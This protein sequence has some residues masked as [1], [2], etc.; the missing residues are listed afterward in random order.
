MAKEA[1]V[2]VLHQ[3]KETLCK[4]LEV[5]VI[6]KRILTPIKT[7]NLSYINPQ[8]PIKT[9]I[10]LLGEIYKT[11]DKKKLNKLVNDTDE[12]IKFNNELNTLIRKA[13]LLNIPVIM[14]I[15][16]LETIKI[17]DKEIEFILATQE[18]YSDFY[19]VPS[20]KRAGKL[21]KEGLEIDEYLNFIKKFI[22]LLES[23]K[24]KP[25]MGLIPM[26]LPFIGQLVK[27]YLKHNI[28]A[29]CLDFDGRASTSLIQNISQLQRTLKNI[30]AF[31]HATN[32]NIGRPLKRAPVIPAKDVLSYGFGI[33]SLGEN[34]LPPRIPEEARRRLGGPRIEEVKNLR[35]FNKEDYGYYK[36]QDKNTL[37]KIYPP[38]TNINL[39][40]LLDKSTHRRRTAQSMFNAEQISIETNRLK[41]VIKE[42]EVAKYLKKK[43]YIKEE[44]KKITKI[45][46]DLTKPCPLTEYL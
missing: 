9:N 5:D 43:E 46:K 7:I 14:F 16:T 36:I 33:D 38:D 17:S 4:I 34:H 10:N 11:L 42:K 25:L 22:E 13:Q 3:D 30:D 28:T 44:F 21:V 18:Y 26:T 12:Q 40:L 35:I 20:I 23:F 37:R 24:E 45:K 39:E 15:P 8:I 19:I 2:K 1:K 27:F 32:M 41:E 6:G 29:Y 31:L